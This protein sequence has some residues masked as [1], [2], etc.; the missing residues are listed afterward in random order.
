LDREVI[1]EPKPFP[2]NIR[3]ATLWRQAYIDC[4]EAMYGI[5]HLSIA[6]R[7]LKD[8]KILGQARKWLLAVAEWS[9]RG[10]TSRA[11]ND[12]AA[13]RTV[14]ALAWGY[15]W[16]YDHLSA[17]DR[18]QVAQVLLERTREVADHVISS[19][20][21]HVFPYDSHAVRAL[22]AALAPCCIA[23]MGES[24]EA[25]EWLDYTVEYLSTL[26]SPWADRDGG[27]AEG[28]HY[29]TTGM[30]YLIDAA[31]LIRN[32]LEVDL[33]QRPFFQRTGDF[34]LYTKAPDT[35]RACFGDDSTL[36]ALPSMKVGYNLRQ[37][38]GV[39]G[40]GVY[41][42]YFEEIK[43][44]D[45]GTEHEFYNYGWWDFNFDELCYRHDYPVVE[46]REP[47]DLQLL[48]HFRG[49]GWAAI[50][51]DMANPDEHIQFLMKSSPFGSVSHSHADQNAFLLYAYGEDLAIQSGYYVAF[52]SD[53]HLNWRR[54]TTSKNA[55]LI[56][57]MGQYAGMDKAMQ[58]KAAG[59]II[60]CR[61]SDG[62]VFIRGDA[63]E[64]YRP[65]VPELTSCIRD[66]H[67]VDQCYFVVVDRVESREPVRIEWLF[68]SVR[69][70][71]LGPNMFRVPA[72]KA[73]LYGQFVFSESGPVSLTQV[74]GFPGIDPD[75]YDGLPEHWHLRAA[76]PPATTHTLVTLLVPYP[77][78]RPMRIYHFLDDQ[79]FDNDLY[80]V[81][82]HDRQYLV[83]LK[84]QF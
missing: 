50:Q 14:T 64:A 33:F 32:A 52:G 19:A 81:D 8:E 24:E 11:Y 69:M 31:R 58:R 27:W 25:R 20:R 83:K 16:L 61:E 54:Q 5:R 23:L 84:K 22:S 53:M 44:N 62:N 10:P 65:K 35:R 29:W 60:E 47:D 36:G 77:K 70:M 49:I 17:V 51:K 75:E 78:D 12:E 73:G 1:A 74:E 82:Q 67:F 9:L 42:W 68:H 80:F 55:L 63:T 6:G 40:N 13:F 72:E 26:Y 76:L 2:S 39:T 7:I 57:G 28:P 15:D 79:G 38:A 46:A 4:Q 56:N 34:P 66:V 48:K 18:E 3:V 43:R 21:I 59:R 45:P 41:Q 30:A 71:E 37:F